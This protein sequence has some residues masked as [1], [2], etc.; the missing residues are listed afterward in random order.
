MNKVVPLKTKSKV[1]T[2][3]MGGH[4]GVFRAA[5]ARFLGQTHQGERDLYKAFGWPHQV[6]V[7]ELVGMYYRNPVASRIVR[8]YPQAT[9]RDMPQI[10]DDKGS[11]GEEK[12]E[13]YSPFAA[14][15]YDFFE[16]RNVMRYLE[17]A[18]RCANL[19]RY[20]LLL[21]GFKDGRNLDE[22][23]AGGMKELLYL[24]P[25][26]EDSIT[27]QKWDEDK[28]SPR[29]GKPE[30]YTINNNDVVSLNVGRPQKTV[31]MNVHWSRLLHVSEF[32]D[33]DDTFGTPR[34]LNVYNSLIDL[35]KV[36]GGSSETFW[37]TANRGLALWAD[38]EANL[39]GEDIAQM[40]EQAEEFQHQISRVLVGRGMQAQPLGSED[41]DPG[42]NAEKL[43]DMISAG[44]GVPKRILIGS[45]RGELSSTQDENNWQQRIKER[46]KNYGVPSILRPFIARMIETGNLPKPEGKWWVE[47]PDEPLSPEA[48]ASVANIKT[49]AIVNYCNAP[50]AQ[51][52]VPY[53]EWRRDVMGLPPESEFET[54]EDDI[55]PED[56]YDPGDEMPDDD[57]ETGDGDVEA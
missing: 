42:P 40:K 13:D 44:S 17:R 26:S 30:I 52:V 36:M 20:G 6:T 22:P 24:A 12:S 11:S 39:T 15:V 55:L 33:Q 35:E 27:V 56:P 3:G 38:K 32:L 28:Q 19:G 53:Q 5:I 29:F 4:L 45:E 57:T 21:M 1:K 23:F 47:W 18:D 14:A 25:Y 7:P 2:N 9:W 51:L 37:I 41:P 50:T 16:E 10:G 54:P 34:L 49:T 8:S 46:R 31:S 43:L 48:A